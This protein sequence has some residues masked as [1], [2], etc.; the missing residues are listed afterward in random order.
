M[1][2]WLL[3]V[4]MGLATARLTR[5]A[6]R[7]DFPPLRIPR[8]W[9]AGPT[10]DDGTTREIGGGHGPGWLGELVT[11]HWC[12]SGWLSLVVTIG[13]DLVTSVPIPVIWW[14]AVWSLGALIT[15][16]ERFTPF[17]QHTVSARVAV[18]YPTSELTTEIAADPR[19]D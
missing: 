10:L 18:E 14:F 17:G 1:A 3:L 5:L 15:H 13:A 7:D 11:C 19:P 12:A 8:D 6:T 4:V 16:Y 9:L 2:P